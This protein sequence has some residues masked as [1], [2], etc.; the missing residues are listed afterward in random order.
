[1]RSVLRPPPPRLLP[2]HFIIHYSHAVTCPTAPE[3]CCDSWPN[4]ISCSQPN[5]SGCGATMRSW[6]IP[7]PSRR[8]PGPHRP[9][10]AAGV[11][12]SALRDARLCLQERHRVGQSAC[13]YWRENDAAW[14]ILAIEA[15]LYSTQTY[16]MLL[17]PCDSLV[18]CEVSPQ[19]PPVR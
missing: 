6:L 1:M 10:I 19:F 13:R 14:V 2:C 5:D 9:S 17:P 12:R 4:P 18:S 16:S 3:L 8:N 7:S 15:E 11:R